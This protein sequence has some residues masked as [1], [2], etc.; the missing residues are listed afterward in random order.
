MMIYAL[1]KSDKGIDITFIEARD[2]L[3]TEILGNF[4]LKQFGIAVIKTHNQTNKWL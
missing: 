3:M 2:L 1:V 4:G